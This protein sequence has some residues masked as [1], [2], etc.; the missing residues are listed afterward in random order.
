MFTPELLHTT[1]EDITEYMIFSFRYSIN[2]LK[3][4]IQKIGYL[5]E[6]MH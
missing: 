4:N 3:K 6:N 5:L 2:N 1:S